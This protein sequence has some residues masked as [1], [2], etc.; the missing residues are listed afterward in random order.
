MNRHRLLAWL[1]SRTVRRTGR[2]RTPRPRWRFVRPCLEVLEDRL[3]FATF[4]VINL[5]DSGDGSLRQAILDANITPGANT[6]D[7]QAGLTGTIK[8]NGALP[9]I[10]SITIHGP[11]AGLTLDAQ[12]KSG[13]FMVGDFGNDNDLSVALS[14]LTL[15]GGGGFLGG[16]ILNLAN[17]LLT[18]CTLADNSAD[19]GGGI[20][21]VFG[22]AELANCTLA[23][24]SADFDGGGIFNEFGRAELAN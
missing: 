17:L 9:I 15:T 16:A 2:A 23:N 4:T 13:I 12:G 22:T 5:N 1:P 7:F 24:N 18:N 8:L 20:F 14:G 3:A 11:A 21:N 19:F 6:I 10:N